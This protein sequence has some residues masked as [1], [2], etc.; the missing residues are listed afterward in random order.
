MFLYVAQFIQTI[1]SVRKS[2]TKGHG[3]IVPELEC[4]CFG[5]YG[6]WRRV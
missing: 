4:V 5:L 2:S 6:K 1:L 3:N